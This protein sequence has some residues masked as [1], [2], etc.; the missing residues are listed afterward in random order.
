[1]ARRARLGGGEAVNFFE[2]EDDVLEGGEVREEVVGLEDG[3]DAGAVFAEGRSGRG[4]GCP[5][6]ETRAGSGSSRPARMRRSVDLPP[7]EGPMR[8]RAWRSGKIEGDGIEHAVGAVGFC[9]GGSWSLMFR[10]GCGAPGTGSRG[11]WGV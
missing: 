10:S 11:R 8:T 4:D 9:D 2:G 3:A 1:M 7:P 6:M 5:S